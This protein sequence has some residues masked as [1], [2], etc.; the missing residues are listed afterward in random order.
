MRKEEKRILSLTATAHT[1]VHLFEL[2]I[3]P[4]FPLLAMAFGVNNFQLGLLITVFSYAFGLGALPAGVLV[5][6]IGPRILMSVYLLGAGAASLLVFISGKFALFAVLVTLMGLFCS[7]YHPSATTLIARTMEKR[8]KAFGIQGIAGSIGTAAAPV[9]AAGIASVFSWRAPFLVFGVLSALIG[10]FSLTFPAYRA[11]DRKPEEARP[12]EDPRR[13]TPVHLIVMYY[14]AACLV[15]LGYKAIMTFLPVYMAENVT[16]N[17]LG[18]DKVTLGGSV[19][20]LALLAGIVG[21]YLSGH[22]ADRVK[23]ELLYLVTVALGTIMAFL[24][25]MSGDF[26]LIAVT[27][28]FAL[29]YFAVQP[30]QNT[31]LPRLVSEKRHGMAYGFFFFT[32]FGVGSTSAAIAGRLAD[33]YDLRIAFLLP[34]GCFAGAVALLAVFLRLYNKEKAR[35]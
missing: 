21:Q 7:V 11:A 19:T 8:G 24:M 16:I 31:L 33:L 27:M 29:F 23:P 1:V 26:V 6:R 15:G 32:T 14:C 13:K 5:D 4:L 2:S 28:F 3:P 34:A 18:M 17:I 9:L 10:I 25:T 30:L 22:L 12:P 35:A 20:T